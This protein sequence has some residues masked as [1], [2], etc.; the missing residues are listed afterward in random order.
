M[1]SIKHVR[2]GKKNRQR[3][4]KY[5]IRN[6]KKSKQVGG[7][8]NIRWVWRTDHDAIVDNLQEQ[9]EQ[10]NLNAGVSRVDK[11]YTI[12]LTTCKQVL[13]CFCITIS[14]GDFL[15]YLDF[16]HT[17][18]AES[19]RSLQELNNIKE[20]VSNLKSGWEQYLKG[21]KENEPLEET[22]KRFAFKK[23]FKEYTSKLEE[24]ERKLEVAQ[25]NME[26]NQR[27]TATS[28]IMHLYWLTS[29]VLVKQLGDIYWKKKLDP[30]IPGNVLDPEIPGDKEAYLKKVREQGTEW[31]KSNSKITYDAPS[32]LNN[33]WDNYPELIERIKSEE[34]YVAGIN[35]YEKNV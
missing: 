30:E 4:K 9:M 2:R 8:P 28:S 25:G 16:F 21:Y 3:S 6:K 12:P 34:S 15:N 18:D 24:K 11:L 29:Q 26:G 32:N 31:I 17:A 13:Y 23:A 27:A 5:T 22:E 20:E 35:L 19:Y 14:G 10:L 7:R 33:I 1:K